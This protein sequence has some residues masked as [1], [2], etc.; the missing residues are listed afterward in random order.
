[1]V[2]NSAFTP[3]S[4]RSGFYL[5][6][7]VTGGPSAYNTHRTA[8]LGSAS[9]STDGGDLNVLV[10]AG[11]DWKKGGLSI[12]PTAN[13][14]YTYVGFSGFT[15]SGS[16]A[17]LKFPDQNSESERTAF[18]IKASYEWKVGRVIVK[19]GNQRRLA[20]RI[21]RTGLLD[22]FQLREWRRQQLY[23]NSPKIGRDSMLVGAGAAVLLNE[24]ISIY[25]YY[26]GEL[27]RTNYQSNNVSGRRPDFLLSPRRSVSASAS[28][29]RRKERHKPQSTDTGDEESV[30]P[31]FTSVISCAQSH[32]TLRDGSL[33]VAVVPGTS[34]QATIGLSLRDVHADISH[35]RESQ[36]DGA[37]VAW[38]EVPGTA[39]PQKSRPVGYG[40]IGAGVRADSMIGGIGV[41]KFR[42][43]IPLS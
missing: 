26:D 1:M 17:P 41:T 13:F 4:F 43:K 3:R 37:I 33:G 39:P 30:A 6:T 24:R 21:R 11:Y 22:C 34:C 38:R 5:D 7:A 20:A 32:R 12:G 19:T 27:G 16:L 14:Q 36:R 25:A 31:G 18:W 9:G 28:V 42:P 29:S 15:E 35:S 2:E 8:L 40:V 23:R 10:A